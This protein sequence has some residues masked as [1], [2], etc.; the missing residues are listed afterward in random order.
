MTVA[1][2]YQQ[3]VMQSDVLIRL[4]KRVGDAYAKKN[5][6]PVFTGILVEA[7]GQTLIMTASN[8]T[9]TV[10]TKEEDALRYSTTGKFLVPARLFIDICNKLASCTSEVCITNRDHAIVIQSGSGSISY[11]VNTMPHDLFTNVI[12]SALV[13]S[14]SVDPKRL[15]RAFQSVEYAAATSDIR[16]ILNA[17]CLS[18]DGKTMQLVAL[19][20]HR[21]AGNTCELLSEA[22][23]F[24]NVV[25]PLDAV[26]ILMK[27]LEQTNQT[28]EV[29][30]HSKDVSFVVGAT[31]FQTKVIEGTYVDTSK[32]I[33]VNS[34]TEVVLNRKEL[35]DAVDRC[36]IVIDKQEQPLV[37]LDIK[38]GQIPTLGIRNTHAKDSLFLVKFEGNEVCIRVHA[39]H[40]LEAI[41]QMQSQEIILSLNGEK[42]ALV[43][44]PVNGD[45]C[46]VIMARKL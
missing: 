22:F 33:P 9:H 24:S 30:L 16:A 25:L 32:L 36:S 14:F 10:E 7:V 3:I 20:S 17:V 29:Q 2:R 12:E 5:H 27:L 38:S 31:T 23:A 34:T 44:R 37:V 43:A 13:Q 11:E 28:V 4:L 1:V 19:D 45:C 46:A 18:G 15:L 39:K 40:L 35:A 41:Q 8:G 21:F 42:A 26:K 6:I